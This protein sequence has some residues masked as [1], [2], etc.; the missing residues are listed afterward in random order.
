MSR[1]K[2]AYNVIDKYRLATQLR[3]ITIPTNSGLTSVVT[4]TGAVALSSTVAYVNT[5]ATEGSTA[6]YYTYLFGIFTSSAGQYVGNFTKRKVIVFTVNC[7][8]DDAQYIRY[9][10]IK[11][12]AGAPA[13]GDLAA[14]GLGVKISN[15]TLLGESFGTEHGE[16]ELMTLTAERSNLIVIDHNPGAGR[17]D[18]YVDGVLKGSQTTAAKVP[19]DIPGNALRY[20]MSIGNG[21]KAAEARLYVSP[22]RI[23]EGV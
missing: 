11:P 3:D 23:M 15:L 16:V 19:N 4:G 10:Q 6:L 20:V 8:G 9:V 22:I 5:A 12:S 18:W 13:H 1:F 14:V 17:I 2:T 7:K 21:T